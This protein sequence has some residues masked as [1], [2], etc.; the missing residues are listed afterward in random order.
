VTLMP[1]LLKDRGVISNGPPASR[2][3]KGGPIAGPQVAATGAPP[4]AASASVIADTV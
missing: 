2:A 4:A 1:E 3:G